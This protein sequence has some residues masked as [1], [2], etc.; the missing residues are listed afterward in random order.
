VKVEYFKTEE[1]S[2]TETLESMTLS[3][4]A[5]KGKIS[6]IGIRHLIKVGERKNKFHVR[7]WTQGALDTYGK[8]FVITESFPGSSKIFDVSWDEPK[9]SSQPK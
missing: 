2:G 3:L 5:H 8:E 7:D 9:K 6:H 4:F 1:Y